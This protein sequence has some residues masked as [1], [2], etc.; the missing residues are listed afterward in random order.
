M[1][2]PS[3]W[4]LV[5]FENDTGWF[6][7]LDLCCPSYYLLHTHSCSY[8]VWFIRAH[9]DIE[10]KVHICFGKLPLKQDYFFIWCQPRIFG[11]GNLEIPTFH[12]P[13]NLHWIKS[14]QFRFSEYAFSR[15]VKQ[16]KIYESCTTRL[17]MCIKKVYIGSFMLTSWW[18]FTQDVF[19][20]HC[21]PFPLFFYAR[22]MCLTKSKLILIWLMH[23]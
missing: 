6:W 7:I 10:V 9:Y 3:I 16:G 20:F 12:H 4:A 19:A 14:T 2:F 15:D 11:R 22:W 21:A 23:F 8:C 13:I 17:G 5:S 18:L 1:T